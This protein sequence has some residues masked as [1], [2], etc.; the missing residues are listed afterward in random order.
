MDKALT[1]L[2]ENI[3]PHNEQLLGLLFNSVAN[4]QRDTLTAEEMV[5]PLDLLFE[6]GELEARFPVDPILR[7]RVLVG[8]A[9]SHCFGNPNS[10]YKW[11]DE[12]IGDHHS[13]IVESCEPSTGLRFVIL[14]S[15]YLI[16]N[17][18]CRTY[19]L[20]RGACFN[21]LVD[22][23]ALVDASFSNIE[24]NSQINE[25][26]EFVRRLESL[27]F[28]LWVSLRW[29]VRAAF[30]EH[31]DILDAGGAIQVHDLQFSLLIFVRITS[32]RF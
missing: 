8:Q 28:K 26:Q 29:A 2:H 20:Q 9:I 31:N 6:F 12:M 11:K 19:F 3:L 13:C 7:P 27:Y 4:S 23:E 16:Q 1:V 17:R 22:E 15:H 30:A 25:T 10:T 24:P 21:N 14:L 18:W 5:S 32:R